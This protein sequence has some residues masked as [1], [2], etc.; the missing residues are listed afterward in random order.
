MNN[1]LLTENLSIW[2]KKHYFLTLVNSLVT[3]V[4]LKTKG[5]VSVLQMFALNRINR[6]RAEL[7]TFRPPCPAKKEIES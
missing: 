2:R 7:L 5:F 6:L 3:G 1:R 4:P